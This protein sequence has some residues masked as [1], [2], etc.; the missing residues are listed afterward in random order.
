MFLN[1]MIVIKKPHR[2]FNVGLGYVKANKFIY[3]VMSSRRFTL[4]SVP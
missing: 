2:V 3:D 4:L 1:Y